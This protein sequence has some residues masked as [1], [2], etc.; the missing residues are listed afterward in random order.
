MFIEKIS[1]EA[2]LAYIQKLVDK[3]NTTS[4]GALR[5]ETDDNFLRLAKVDEYYLALLKKSGVD[6]D[7]MMAELKQRN[8]FFK[9]Y[10]NF[11]EDMLHRYSHQ[12]AFIAAFGDTTVKTF[13]ANVGMRAYIHDSISNTLEFLDQHQQEILAENSL[14]INN[15]YIKEFMLP[16]LQAL[17]EQQNT[18]LVAD[19]KA[20]LARKFAKKKHLAIQNVKKHLQEQQ[21]DLGLEK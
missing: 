1:D 6:L 8:I 16:N 17:D 2:K 19:Y 3:E 10:Q 21:E 15:S 11:S 18:H 9:I 20:A 12:Y 7:K 4:Y 14:A 5:S 13:K